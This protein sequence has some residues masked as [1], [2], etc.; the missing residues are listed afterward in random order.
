MNNYNHIPTSMNEVRDIQDGLQ[1]R[2]LGYIRQHHGAHLN[3][4]QLLLCTM[5]H[6]QGLHAMSGE[7]AETIAARALCEFESVR[8]S[9]SLDLESSTPYMLVI[10]D[11]DRN[12]KR[13]FSM[14]DIR[15]MLST[16]DLTPMRTPSYSAAMAGTTQAQ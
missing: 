8:A 9:L 15:R 11:P 7:T 16:A 6:I 10:N 5:E 12:C 1:I 2:A 3:R 4:R 14:R 13:V